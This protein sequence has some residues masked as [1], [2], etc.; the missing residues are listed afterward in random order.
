M[1]RRQV[2]LPAGTAEVWNELT[3]PDASRHWMGGRLEWELDPGG[4]VRFE[5]DDG[6][7]RHGRIAEV[8][9][10]RSLRFRWWP[11]DDETSAS[12]VSYTLDPDDPGTRLTVTEQPVPAESAPLARNTAGW[13]AWDDRLVGIW[14]SA[15]VGVRA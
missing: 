9:P 10:G 5:G 1:I 15:C 2:L 8:E 6:S 11:D 7:V 12:D 3:D 14:A 4:Q 13:T